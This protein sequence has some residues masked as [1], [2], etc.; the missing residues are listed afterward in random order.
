MYLKHGLDVA[1]FSFVTILF[2]QCCLQGPDEQ[3]PIC[4]GHGQPCTIRTVM[5][6]GPNNG[7]RFFT[8]KLPKNKQCKFF[9]WAEGYD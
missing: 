3:F 2:P 5:K 8:C 1:N 7:G 4:A 6:I 9:E